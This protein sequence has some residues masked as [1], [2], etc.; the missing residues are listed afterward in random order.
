MPE[1]FAADSAEPISEAELRS[2][3]ARHLPAWQQACDADDAE[4]IVLHE[5]SFGSSTR[6]LFLFACAIKYAAAK[7]KHV[8]VATGPGRVRRAPETVLPEAALGSV[9]REDTPLKRHPVHRGGAKR[10]KIKK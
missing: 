2:L 9:Y 4:S 7:G 10:A 6:E 1:V 5:A 8:H 3:I